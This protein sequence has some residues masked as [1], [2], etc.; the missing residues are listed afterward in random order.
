[1]SDYGGGDDDVGYD[2]GGLEYVH[3]SEKKKNKTRTE[4]STRLQR[5]MGICSLLLAFA[6]P[7]SASSYLGAK[8]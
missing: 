4:Q 8:S 7:T 2:A 6:A 1:M 5:C 3:P